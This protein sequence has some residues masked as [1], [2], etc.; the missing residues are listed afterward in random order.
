MVPIGAIAAAGT[1]KL[2]ALAVQ[3]WNILYD[4]LQSAAGNIA[5]SPIV[6]QNWELLVA[7]ESDNCCKQWNDGLLLLHYPPEDLCHRNPTI[8]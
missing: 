3:K 5:Y 2:N 8:F 1:V 4:L 6:R 7:V